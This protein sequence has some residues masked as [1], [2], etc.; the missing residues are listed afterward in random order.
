MAKLTKAKVKGC[1]KSS[2]LT[3]AT[4]AGVIGGVI[5]GLCLRQREQPWTDREV[6]YISYVGELFLRMLKALILPLI[7]PSLIAA[8]GSLDM[9]LSGRVGGRAVAY[10][11]TTTVMAVILGII[12]V[13]I[14]HPGKPTLNDDEIEKSGESRNVTAADTLMDLGRNL[15]PPNLVKATVAQYRTVLVN[16]GEAAFVDDAGQMRDPKNLYTWAI[17]GEYSD[18]TNILGLVFFA[19]ILGITLAIMEERG[20]PLLDFFT[21]LSEAMMTITTWVIYMAPVGVFFLIGGQIL[22]MEDMSMVAGQ[23]GMYFFTVML[24][25]FFHG[26]V[27][28]PIVYAVCTRRMPFRFIANMMNAFTTAFGTASSSAT[29]PVT[30]NLLEEKNGVDPRIARF[31]LP[32]GATINMDGT[33]LYEAVAAIFI[34]QVRSMGLSIGQIIAISITATA[35]SIGAAGIPQAGLVTMVMVLDTVGLP[36]EDVTIILAVDWLLDRFRTAINVLGDSIGAGLVYELSKAELELFNQ[37]KIEGGFEAVPMNEI[38]ED[39]ATTTKDR[40]NK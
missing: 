32:I 34:S 28:L 14:I 11:M 19:V 23:L 24:G 39:N 38:D 9:S 7:V 30:I 6:M 2:A 3:F 17:K 37:G 29:L 40:N 10:Y 33:A 35:A 18:S 4:L 13:T 15:L 1:L 21:C 26:F 36:A 16:P 31:V 27:V 5:F 22:G 12:L 20:K 8:V 25:L